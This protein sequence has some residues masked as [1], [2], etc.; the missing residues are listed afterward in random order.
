[1]CSTVSARRPLMTADVENT[2]R[3]EGDDVVGMLVDGDGRVPADGPNGPLD[4]T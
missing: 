3:V 1:M 2:V 4:D